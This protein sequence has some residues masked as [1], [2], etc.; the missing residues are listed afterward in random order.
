M[1]I[2]KVLR[3]LP[4]RF[5]MK[6]LAIEETHDLTTMKLDELLRSLRTYE[7]NLREKEQKSDK[8]TK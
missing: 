4:E 2:S 7:M 5:T 3:T 8:K 6:A 1:F